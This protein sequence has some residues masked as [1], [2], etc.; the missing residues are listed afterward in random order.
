MASDLFKASQ[1]QINLK[2]WKY[3]FVVIKTI[4]YLTIITLQNYLE[5]AEGVQKGINQSLFLI[6]V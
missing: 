4:I 5:V 1:D 6:E 2:K 3:Y